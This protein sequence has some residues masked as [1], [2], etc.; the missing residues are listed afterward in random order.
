VRQR[1][2]EGE[3]RTVAAYTGVARRGGHQQ[4]ETKAGGPNGGGLREGD[5]SRRS[6]AV[7]ARSASP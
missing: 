4:C 7:W 1:S 6:S 5:T 3:G 2:R